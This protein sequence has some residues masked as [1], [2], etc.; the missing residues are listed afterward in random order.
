MY[1]VALLVTR[2][3]AESIFTSE[4]LA[5]LGTFAEYNAP[6][7]LPEV[8]TQDFMREHLK[9]ADTCVTCWGTPSLTADMLTPRLKLVAHAAGTIKNLIPP[10]LWDTRCRV[11][12]NANVIARDVAQ[13]VLAFTLT[14]LA[15]LWTN[16]R[17]TREGGW[18][19]GE[20]GTFATRRLE[21]LNIGLVG[22]SLVC[23]EVI[24]VFKPYDCPIYV[25]DPFASPIEM[26]ELGVSY[27][28]LDELIATSD[29]LSLHAPANEDCRH[30]LNARNLPLLKDGALFINTA[31][32]ML[33]DEPALIRELQTGRIFACID[34]TDPEPPRADHPFRT[35]PNVVLTS[36]VAGGHSANGRKKL[37][38]AVIRRTY[39]YLTRGLLENEVRREMLTHMA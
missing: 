1:N 14:S 8:M 10:E 5:F 12:S 4:D 30:M 25:Y 39:D 36:H 6:D 18:K 2:A 21:G 26:R 17:N 34:V 13:T 20:S 32:G 33:I 29:I 3:M 28:P 38:A 22:L 19:G 37:G 7:T 35:L 15:G 31:R 24:K 23:R 27:L 9:D 11:T 16:A